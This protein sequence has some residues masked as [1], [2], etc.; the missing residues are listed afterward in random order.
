M[1]YASQ[2]YKLHCV[3]KKKKNK[4]HRRKRMGIVK[5][6]TEREY[7]SPLLRRE[8]RYFFITRKRDGVIGSSGMPNG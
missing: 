7:I 4:L 6:N 8:R 2:K 3:K 1:I 5:K